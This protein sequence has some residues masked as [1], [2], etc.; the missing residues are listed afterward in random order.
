MT[1]EPIIEI[2]DDGCVRITVGEY[3]G[4]VS[5][6]HLVDTKVNQLLQC[7]QSNK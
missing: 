5:S 2:L 7:Y 6:M 1:P 4:I 3:Y